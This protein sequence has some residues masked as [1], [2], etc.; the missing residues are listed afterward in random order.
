MCQ[1]DPVNNSFINQIA[2][3]KPAVSLVP[4]SFGN[5]PVASPYHC[6]LKNSKK[7][8]FLNNLMLKC[9]D[10]TLQTVNLTGNSGSQPVDTHSSWFHE[11]SVAM[12]FVILFI[13]KPFIVTVWFSGRHGQNTLSWFVG[14]KETIRRLIIDG[15]LGSPHVMKYLIRQHSNELHLIL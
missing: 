9:Y 2:T 15:Q 4:Q 3:I 1:Q 10:L 12:V 6:L 14:D 5:A 7:Y 8:F 11:A 13:A